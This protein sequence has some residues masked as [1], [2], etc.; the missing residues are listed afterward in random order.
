MSTDEDTAGRPA[1]D[2]LYELLEETLAAWYDAACSEDGRVTKLIREAESLSG[3]LRKALEGYAPAPAE[4]PQD[5]PRSEP[6]AGGDIVSKLRERI[7]RSDARMGR[8]ISKVDALTRALQC[9]RAHLLR[10]VAD[11]GSR[12]HRRYTE[13]LARIDEALADGEPAA[14]ERGEVERLRAALIRIARGYDDGIMCTTYTA[15][16]CAEIASAALQPKGSDSE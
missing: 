9:E 10:K 14:G 8:M 3:R 6:A 7:S 2:E 11:P 16:E 15:R 1:R 5:A 4:R 12:A 13:R